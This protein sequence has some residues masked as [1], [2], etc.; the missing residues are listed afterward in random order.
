MVQCPWAVTLEH[1]QRFA[2]LFDENGDGVISVNEFHKFCMFIALASYLEYQSGLDDDDGFDQEVA[3][4]DDLLAEMIEMDEQDRSEID[5]LLEEIKTDKSAIESNM[6]KIPEDVRAYLSSEEFVEATVEKFNGVDEDRNGVLT[7][8]EI[9]TVIEDLVQCPWAITLDHCHKFVQIFDADGDGVISV[10]E[11]HD[12]CIFVA[13]ISY[14]EYQN[15]ASTGAAGG[16]GGGAGDDAAFEAELEAES[17]DITQLIAEV[18]ADKSAVERNLHRIPKRIMAHISSQQ[19]GEATIAKFKSVDLDG[20][21]VLTPDELFPVIEEMVECPWAITIEHCQR[22]AKV[23]DDNGD[24]VISVEEFV[25]F[26]QFLTLI[27]YLEND[28]D[29][30]GDDDEEEGE[31]E[32][33]G[34]EGEDAGEEEGAR[35]PS[36]RESA[37]S[38]LDGQYE[39]VGTRGSGH[40]RGDGGGGGDGGG[41]SVGGGDGGGGGGGDGSGA[42]AGG[43]G[44]GG[45]KADATPDIP[46]FLR[47]SSATPPPP[48]ASQPSSSTSDGGF[49]AALLPTQRPPP[50]PHQPTNPQPHPPTHQQHQQHQTNNPKS[51]HPRYSRDPRLPPRSVR[52]IG[53]FVVVV[54]ICTNVRR[55]FLPRVGSRTRIHIYALGG[56]SSARGSARGGGDYPRR[57]G[58]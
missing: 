2:L 50:T 17:N 30:E 13:L 31:D 43:G 6:H 1:C 44:G 20:N 11:F 32:E 47:S 25:A 18:A 24:G 49:I 29:Y 36:S 56:T 48:S 39:T 9:F 57:H 22:F 19:F 53:A 10:G 23:F 54:V 34:D 16:A 27:S 15:E 45:V 12:F 7:V 14:L 21:G 26:C 55:S 38:Y 28:N 33:G 58:H 37:R 8:D 4:G 40:G 3:D 51:P 46:S 52:H 41:D 5:R 35:R 42:G